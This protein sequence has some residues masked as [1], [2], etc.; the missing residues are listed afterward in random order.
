M[1][2]KIRRPHSCLG[3]AGWLFVILSIFVFLNSAYAWTQI[4]MARAQAKELAKELGYTQEGF[5]RNGMEVANVDIFTGSA[6]CRA[7]L[8]FIT[9]LDLSEFEAKL[10]I[11]FP[12][13]IP[14]FHGLDYRTDLYYS[15]PLAVAKVSGEESKT[16][17]TFPTIPTKIWFLPEERPME[18]STVFFYQTGQVPAL[19]TF[20]SRQISGNITVIRWAAGRYPIWVWC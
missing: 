14:I 7:E 19:L 11:A 17:A 15:L 4:Y 9:P 5:L 18:Q 3:C 1:N 16:V 6:E 13:T 20:G 8:Y 10:L 12:G 2:F